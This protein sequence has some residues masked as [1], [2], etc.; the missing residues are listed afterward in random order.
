MSIILYNI[1]S[2]SFFL[3]QTTSGFLTLLTESLSNL[4]IPDS[5]WLPPSAGLV[6]IVRNRRMGACTSQ[7]SNTWNGILLKKLNY[8]HEFHKRW[9]NQRNCSILYN[10]LLMKP[11]QTG[12]FT[13][14]LNMLS[15]NLHQPLPKKQTKIFPLKQS[16]WHLAL[17]CRMRCCC[18]SIT[19][20][21]RSSFAKEIS[22]DS[23]DRSK[24]FQR[25][26]CGQETPQKQL[27]RM[28]S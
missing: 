6:E 9:K 24:K 21:R 22:M 28:S 8:V 7:G 19:A 20:T 12:K 5:T 15:N 3:W 27:C 14:A 23:K 10:P 25:R 4:N 1:E 11:S 17:R 16:V 2:L 18:S 13:C 26:R